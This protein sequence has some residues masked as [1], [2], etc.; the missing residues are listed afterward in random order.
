MPACILVVD[1]DE[2]IREFVQMALSDEG[3]SVLQAP[4]GSVALEIVKRERVDLIIL[5]MRMPVMDGWAFLTAYQ[6]VASPRAPV[7][8]VSANNRAISATTADVVDF[9]PKPFDLGHLLDLVS[10]HTQPPTARNKQ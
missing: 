3:Y 7:I 9:I 1:D 2:S 8:A 4:N 6:Q 5:D 10:S